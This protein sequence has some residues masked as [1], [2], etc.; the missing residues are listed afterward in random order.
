MDW[1]SQ[2]ILFRPS[3]QCHRRERG[4]LS[5]SADSRASLALGWDLNP[6][7]LNSPAPCTPVPGKCCSAPPQ[8]HMHGLSRSADSHASLALC[9]DLNP[10]V[11]KASAL[12]AP[13][14]GKYC[15]IPPISGLWLM[16]AGS[17]C[18]LKRLYTFFPQQYREGIAFSHHGLCL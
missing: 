15:S 3:L 14:L 17:L 7:V 1:V 2:T 5:H 8:C 13:V 6:D 18:P 12:H 10:D 4:S 9:W 16:G 11:L